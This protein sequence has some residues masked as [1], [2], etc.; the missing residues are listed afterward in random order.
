MNEKP[1]NILLVEDDPDDTLLI[2]QALAEGNGYK[3]H[4]IH[5]D[6]LKSCLA[7]LPSVEAD[8]VL[9]DLS[10]PDS[11]GLST[12]LAVQSQPHRLPIV[13]LT[14]LN[15]EKLA[16]QAV[17]AGAQDYLVKG[18]VVGQSLLRVLRAAV[19]RNRLWHDLKGREAQIRRLIEKNVDGMIVVDRQGVVRLANPSAVKMLNRSGSALVGAAFE[20]P[21]QL[22]EI[23]KL[24]LVQPHGENLKVEMRMVEI[25]WETE[26]AYLVSLHDVTERARAEEKERQLIRL[27]EEFIA[28]ISHDLRTPLSGLLGFL[29]LLRSGKVK[30]PAEQNEF[31][32]RMAWDVDRLMMIVNELLDISRLEHGRFRLNWETVDMG[33][34][35][36]ETLHFLQPLA[37]MK[38]ISLQHLSKDQSFIV[39]AD[40]SRMRRVLSNLVENAI[41][42][43]EPGDAVLVDSKIEPH[44]LI[45]KVI[46]EGCGISTEDQS[47]MFG[48]FFQ[49][50]GSF[51]R[52][53]GGVGLGLY[54]SKMIVEAHGGS[55]HL[56]S[57]LGV[58]STFTITIP[59]QKPVG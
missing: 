41:K 49:T 2:R 16:I 17:Q 36:V 42:F 47:K 10:L 9:L 56:E 19:E 6:H 26:A 27:R 50:G 31:Y 11:Q 53:A 32:T 43:S 57:E 18:Q 4:L 23:V 37:D 30:N 21:I 54:T 24:D 40:E 51:K 14:G 1:L 46:D 5:F 39:E 59:L 44:S 45:I 58:G 52:G 3:H 15:D 33:A 55:I 25:E 20:F 22:G 28:G 29:N 38:R 35:I 8:I 12:L 34:I 13:I 48:K 7:Q